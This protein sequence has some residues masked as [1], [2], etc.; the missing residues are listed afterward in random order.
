M[1]ANV[2]VQQYLQEQNKK[3]ATKITDNLISSGS[4]DGYSYTYAASIA[5]QDKQIDKA[6]TM[7]K[8]A[9]NIDKDIPEAHYYLSVCYRIKDDMPNAIKEANSAREL[10]S[11]PFFDSYYDE[12]EKIKE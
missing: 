7:A 4:A 5:L 9:I 2:A 3:E 1:Q 6:E 12:L 11:N 8:E 10:S